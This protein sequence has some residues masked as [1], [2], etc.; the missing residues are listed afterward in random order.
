MK[1]NFK[2]IFQKVEGLMIQKWFDPRL[3]HENRRT[4]KQPY[5]NAIHHFDSL[6]TP[7]CLVNGGK[8]SR[9]MAVKALEVF[10]NGTVSSVSQ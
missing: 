1:F 5:L 4:G 10:P 9:K 2:F 6:W 8:E 3:I 7:G